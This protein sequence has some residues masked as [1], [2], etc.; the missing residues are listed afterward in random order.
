MKED[1]KAFFFVA[2]GILLTLLG[3]GGVENS[4]TTVELLQSLAVAG[5]GLL[6]MWIATL[7]LKQAG[8]R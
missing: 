1:T 4:M 2:M 5:L 3:V 7:I 8:Y 6:F